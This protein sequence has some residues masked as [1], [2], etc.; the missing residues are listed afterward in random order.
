MKD[1]QSYSKWN[2]YTPVIETS[3]G[4]NAVNPGDDITLQYRPESTGDTTPIPCEIISV[5]DEERS[6][7]WRGKALSIPTWIFLPE[8]VQRVISKGDDRCFYE[9]W[10]TQSG[11]MAYAVKWTIGMKLSAMNQGIADGL[12]KFVEGG[13]GAMS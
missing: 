8:K 10:E 2:L 7:C 1:F 4:S 11:P 13:A 12:K 5:S 6:I 9:I 3:S